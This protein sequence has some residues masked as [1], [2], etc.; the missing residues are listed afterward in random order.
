MK[1]NIIVVH[2]SEYVMNQAYLNGA[3][4][5]RRSVPWNCNPHREDSEAHEAWS[6]GHVNDSAGEH[7]RF[8]KDLVAVSRNGARFEMDPGVPR[9]SCGDVCDD[10]HSQ[11][12]KT[13]EQV[14]RAKATRPQDAL[15]AAL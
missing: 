1:N 4:A 15:A 2:D 13:F 8:G 3:Q 6:N 9:Q 10:W 11:Q 5:F 14:A 7:Y 12:R